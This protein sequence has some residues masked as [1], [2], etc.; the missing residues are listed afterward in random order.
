M[1][2]KPYLLAALD[3]YGADPARWPAGLL[4]EAD[5]QRGSDAEF[6]ARWREAARLDG[7]LEQALVVP[8]AP[9]GYGKRMAASVLERL[10][11]DRQ[12]RLTRMT[13]AFGGSWA[14][15][16]MIAGLIVSQVLTTPDNDALA[17]AEIALGTTSMLTGN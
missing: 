12:R 5:E 14:A 2:E 4:A 7:M 8:E 17:Y 1:S 3:R 10:R 11:R 16:A 15:A 9:F 6:A 13:L